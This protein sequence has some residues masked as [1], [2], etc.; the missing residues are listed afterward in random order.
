M[1][2]HAAPCGPAALG[3]AGCALCQHWVWALGWCRVPTW[4]QGDGL[5]P[6]EPPPPSPPKDGWYRLCRCTVCS[7]GSPEAPPCLQGNAVLCHAGA[8]PGG[9]H[10]PWALLHAQGRR[11]GKANPPV[12][13][14]RAPRPAGGGGWGWGEQGQQAV[15]RAG[16]AQCNQSLHPGWRMK[17]RRR[18]MDGN[19]GGSGVREAPNGGGGGLTS[20]L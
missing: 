1:G 15:G 13:L 18:T 4:P 7:V 14:H 19:R 20:G 5:V 2:A 6:S 3:G 16:C 9:G 17:K 11:W 12:R 10:H 8:S